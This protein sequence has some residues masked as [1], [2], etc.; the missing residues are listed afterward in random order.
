MRF[1]W[2][3]THDAAIAFGLALGITRGRIALMLGDPITMNMVNA[4]ARKNKFRGGRHTHPPRPEVPVDA[5]DG[6]ER[7]KLERANDMFGRMLSAAILAGTENDD[8]FIPREQFCTER[9]LPFVR[10][11]HVNGVPSADRLIGGIP[12]AEYMRRWREQQAAKQGKAAPQSFRPVAQEARR[13]RPPI[14]QLTIMDLADDTCRFPVNDGPEFLFCGAKPVKGKPYCAAC[15]RIAYGYVPARTGG[16]FRLWTPG[17]PP[18]PSH[19]T[20]AA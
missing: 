2:T 18:K 7:A 17:K 10:P 15:C 4:R 3:Q 9:P 13:E 19:Q 8:H 11:A 6:L 16:D 14:G 20:E 1:K 5:R 12:R